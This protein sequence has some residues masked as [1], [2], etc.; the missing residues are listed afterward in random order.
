VKKQNASLPA[1]ADALSDLGRE[2]RVG[3]DG[4]GWF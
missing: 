1:I 3:M 4:R 2:M